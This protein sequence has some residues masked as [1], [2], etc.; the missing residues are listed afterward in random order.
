MSLCL[1]DGYLGESRYKNI[2]EESAIPQEQLNPKPPEGMVVFALNL[3]KASAVPDEGE[4]IPK[5][6][7]KG[8]K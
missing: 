4:I 7:S 3:L 8:G 1:V 6:I 2:A 5:E